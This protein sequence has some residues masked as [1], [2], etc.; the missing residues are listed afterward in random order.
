MKNLLER[1]EITV[2]NIVE[3]TKRM[4][5]RK[6]HVTYIGAGSGNN[7]LESYTF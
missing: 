7:K 1:R 4:S 6:E 3:N 5:R 2:Y